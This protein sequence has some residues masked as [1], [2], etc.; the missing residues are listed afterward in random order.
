LLITL[1]P[2]LLRALEFITYYPEC[3]E[4]PQF[5]ARFLFLLIAFSLPPVPSALLVACFAS[6]VATAHLSVT[7]VFDMPTLR[8]AFAE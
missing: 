5:A 3:I 6:P 4:P 1:F 2:A 7:H 8:P